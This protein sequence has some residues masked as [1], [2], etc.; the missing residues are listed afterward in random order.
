[1]KGIFMRAWEIQALEDHRKS[2]MRRA[3]RP[4]PVNVMTE[5]ERKYR[6]LSGADPYGFSVGT[7]DTELIRE[8]PWHP[9][10]ILYVKESF[11]KDAGRFMYKADYSSTEKFYCAG[12]EVCIHWESPICMPREAARLFLR[13]TNLRVERLQDI[14]CA[15]AQK[16]GLRYYDAVCQD[17]SW[18]PTFADPD[19]GCDS[20]AILGFSRLWDGALSASDR[21]LFGWDANPWVRVTEFEQIS[22]EEAERS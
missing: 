8:A 21:K 19:S 22:R 20:S 2:E 5:E 7:L 15:G 9:G 17:D 12:K 16:E 4:Q 10:D 13:V 6:A 18:H 14:G 3:I 1:M 11:Y